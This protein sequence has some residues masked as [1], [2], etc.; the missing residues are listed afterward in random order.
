MMAE[1][2]SF[3]G[4]NSKQLVHL[5][6]KIKKM[7]KKKIFCPSR[8]KIKTW[9]LPFFFFVKLGTLSLVGHKNAK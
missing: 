2:S 1:L 4:S 8:L 5:K 9:A 7:I 3:M 6:C